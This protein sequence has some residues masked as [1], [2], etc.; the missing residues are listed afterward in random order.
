[1]RYRKPEPERRGPDAVLAWLL[2]RPHGPEGHR[3]W[4]V[5]CPGPLHRRGDQRPSLSVKQREGDKLLLTCRSAKCPTEQILAA[6]AFTLADLFYDTTERSNG[7]S[8]GT[9]VATYDYLNET[10]ELAHQVVR[11]EPKDFKCRRPDGRGGWIWNMHGVQ[12]LLYHRDEL[13]G[14]TRVY[15]AEGEKCA[16]AV[17][18]LGLVATTNHGGAGKWGDAHTEQLVAA[19]VKEVVIFA[20]HDAPGERHARAVA[21]ACL[22]AGLRVKIV[23]FP[24]LPEAADVSDYLD[25]GHSREAL[26]ARVDAAP[27]AA[28]ADVRD[29]EPA[30][31]S[32]GLV[33]VLASDVIAKPVSWLWPRRLA[34]G[35][36]TL[37]VGD[38]G[39]GKSL[40]TVDVAARVSTGGEWPDGGDIEAGHVVILSAEDN[41]DDTLKPRL[42]AAGARLDNITIV[43]AA[44]ERGRE[45]PFSLVTDL[46]RLRG[47]IAERRAVLVVIDPVNAYLASPG[48]VLDSYKDTDIRSVLTPI[49]RLT[50]DTGVAMI[51]LMHMN[52]SGQG[53]AIY[54]VLGSVG[55]LAGAR[56]GLVVAPD[57]ED[58][59]VKLVVALKSNNSRPAPPLAFRIRSAC[60]GC[61]RDLADDL[62]VCMRC[63]RQATGAIKWVDVP[64]GRDLTADALLQQ[65]QPA[66]DP[67]AR[68]AAEAFLREALKDGEVS[69]TEIIAAGKDNNIGRNALFDTKKKLGIEARRLG[70]TGDTRGKGAWFW[71]LPT[72]AD[73]TTPTTVKTVKR[74]NEAVD[75]KDETDVQPFNRLTVRTGES[76]TRSVIVRRKPPTRMRYPRDRI[77]AD[78]AACRWMTAHPDDPPPTFSARG[79]LRHAEGA[80]A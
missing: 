35:K 22:A 21:R 69:S 45:R 44:R 59:G 49:K 15:V 80:G 17:A 61:R 37:E 29:A 25:A 65:H 70:I 77:L 72:A 75:L 6:G 34:A 64:E 12:P 66:V 76:D 2:G 54:R 11:Y 41:A 43:Q 20:D 55:Y 68:S 27:W 3:A 67:D 47:L 31:A 36:L 48:K 73:S 5:S 16:D 8:P 40:L 62:A 71:S 42:E 53:K 33:S 57:R 1:M 19:G 7:S 9:I 30:G 50:E 13:T 78:A 26:L 18:A 24:E 14:I 23:G 4:K 10:S 79:Y 32:G 56:A 51:G 63:R 38:T 28:P 39:H 52:K 58:E 74:L 60:P 46:D